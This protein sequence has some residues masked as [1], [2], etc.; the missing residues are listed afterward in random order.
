M[1]NSNQSNTK[2][3]ANC[4]RIKKRVQSFVVLLP[5]ESKNVLLL[6]DADF[7]LNV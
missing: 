1:E 2:I 3:Q 4:I 6:I 7:R 5:C